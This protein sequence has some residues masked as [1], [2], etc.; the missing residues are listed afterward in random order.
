[1][2]GLFLLKSLIWVFCAILFL[3]G[4]ALVARR[5]L[6]LKGYMFDPDPVEQNPPTAA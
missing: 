4:L 2:E 1:M 3:Q 5:I 6:F